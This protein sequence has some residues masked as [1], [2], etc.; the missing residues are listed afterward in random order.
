MLSSRKVVREA[1]SYDTK[2][3]YVENATEV[4]DRRGPEN[5]GLSCMFTHIG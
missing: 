1:C 4:L 5:I 2:P 3:L